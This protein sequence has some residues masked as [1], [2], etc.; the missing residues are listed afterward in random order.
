M[1]LDKE[2]LIKH[3]F[4]IGFGVL[5]LLMLVT[6][7]WISA[8]SAEDNVTKKQALDAAKAS[9]DSN[10]NK[11]PRNKNEINELK[12][13]VGVLEKRREEVWKKAWEMQESLQTWPKAML[14]GSELEKMS[15]GD[16]IKDDAIR[17][18]YA[19][20]NVYDKEVQGLKDTFKVPVVIDKEEKVF[21]MVQLRDDK[22]LRTVEDWTKLGKAPS[23]EEVWLAQEDIWVQREIL[24]SIREAVTTVA[25]FTQS[26]EPPAA[27]RGELFREVYTNPEWQMDLSLAQKGDNYL[28]KGRIKNVTDHP[29]PLG[30]LFFNLQL[31]QGDAKPVLLEV[32]GPMLPAGKDWPIAEVPLNLAGRPDGILGVIQV[33][34]SRTSPIR[35]LDEIVMG[36]QAH[37][38]F[39]S[40]LKPAEFSKQA[41]A[42]SGGTAGAGKDKDKDAAAGNRTANGLMRDRYM[43]V[44]EQVRRMPV[45]IVVLI[46]QNHAPELLAALTNSRLRLQ[47]TQV[48]WQHFRGNLAPPAAPVAPGTK[49]KAG[50]AEPEQQGNLIE[51]V[52]YCSASLYERYKPGTKVTAV[53]APPT[54]PA[55]PKTPPAKA[56]TT[57]PAKD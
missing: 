48:A 9:L 13:R 35:R 1:K 44:T 42:K 5:L 38:L 4:W 32:Q 53:G 11:P 16:D 10:L 51:L 29:L 55:Q 14:E 49:P 50:D 54:G 52:I 33:F 21:E 46:D 40:Q 25:K 17:G 57:E 56:P 36:A 15:F 8:V 28:L 30:K 47:V 37:R 3:Q 6:G 23:S 45:G 18:R 2:T 26:K 7:I 31:H 41:A 43:D 27:G 22:T 12:K 34:D 19:N 24:N 20:K 39:M